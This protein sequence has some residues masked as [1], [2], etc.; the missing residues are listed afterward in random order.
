MNLM[1]ETLGTYIHLPLPVRIYLLTYPIVT[2]KFV[3][4]SY[5]CISAE[6]ITYTSV[7]QKHYLKKY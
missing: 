3:S 1:L 7:T 6:F 5:K 4:I 2:L